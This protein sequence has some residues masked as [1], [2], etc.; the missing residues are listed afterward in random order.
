VSLTIGTIGFVNIGLMRV[1]KVTAN[2]APD[3]FGVI[4]YLH[5]QPGLRMTYTPHQAACENHRH[6]A[7]SYKHRSLLNQIVYLMSSYY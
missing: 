5:D 2:R 7:I 1:L 4:A 6:P 3:L